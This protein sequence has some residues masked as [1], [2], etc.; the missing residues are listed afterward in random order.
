MVHRW[1]YF[2]NTGKSEAEPIE[3]HS[4]VCP[5]LEDWYKER[6]QGLHGRSGSVAFPRTKVVLATAARLVAEGALA[7]R[8]ER[9]AELRRRVADIVISG[10]VYKSVLCDIQKKW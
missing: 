7:R 10:I 1:W 9:R 2:W 8:A 5:S 4:R 6:E 3:L